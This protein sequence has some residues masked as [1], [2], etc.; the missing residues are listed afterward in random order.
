MW[1]SRDSRPNCVEPGGSIVGMCRPRPRGEG[2]AV[3]EMLGGTSVIAP[4]V[5]SGPE[6]L[7]EGVKEPIVDSQERDS[8]DPLVD[9][10]LKRQGFQGKV[11]LRGRSVVPAPGP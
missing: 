4:L 7:T 2:W 3:P 1:G 10:S 5:F 6:L 8:G 9:E 11:E